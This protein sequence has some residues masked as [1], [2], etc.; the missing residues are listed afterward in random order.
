MSKRS[1][2]CG[3]RLLAIPIRGCRHSCAASAGGTGWWVAEVPLS[4]WWAVV[5]P[6]PPLARAGKPDCVRLGA[7]L[8]HS[9][10]CP[11][12]PQHWGGHG[13]L[14]LLSWGFSALG[15]PSPPVVA[16]SARPCP[17]ERAESPAMGPCLLETT[18]SHLLLFL[19]AKRLH[20]SSPNL[21]KAPKPGGFL[22]T[23]PAATEP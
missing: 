23:L 1:H 2:S 7:L 15:R 11:Q 18:R 3:L 20:L 8:R 17:G 10:Q 21:A 22:F 19:P 6:L 5:S 13:H 9:S 12:C 16:P 14:P 4:L